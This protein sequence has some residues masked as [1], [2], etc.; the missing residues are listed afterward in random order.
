MS[1]AQP[2]R[3]SHRR[4]QG[5]RCIG[6]RSRRPSP[7]SGRAPH[8]RRP[9]APRARCGAGRANG[10][11]TVADWNVTRD[12][13]APRANARPGVLGAIPAAAPSSTTS[14]ESARSRMRN[15]MRS[16]T[17][18][19]TSALRAPDGRWVARTRWTPRDRPWAASRTRPVTNSGSSSTRARSS[20][21]TTTS[22]GTCSAPADP[23]PLVAREVAGADG[24]QDPLAPTQ[25]G[26]QGRQRARDQVVVEVGDQPDDVGEAG[27]RAEGRAALEVDQDEGELLGR[28]GDGQR[29]DQGAEELRLAR[30]GGATDQHVRPVAAQVDDER[31][32]GVDPTTAGRVG[33]AEGDLR[34]VT[35]RARQ[36]S[37]TPVPV[38]S[39]PKASARV[40]RDGIPTVARGSEQRKG[41]S[42]RESRSTHHGATRSGTKVM[43]AFGPSS[44]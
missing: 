39:P 19:C 5:G 3:L 41:A 20:S 31:A 25:L 32:L 23:K 37:A 2:V 14:T 42:A 27:A 35:S 17:F 36:R 1:T 43:H 15:A 13:S 21:T 8:R 38:S 16:E 9:A 4:H 11:A 6:V 34:A 28:C 22:R 7:S 12:P 30:A 29:G 44:R 26:T 40:R 33:V 18:A 10:G 24:G